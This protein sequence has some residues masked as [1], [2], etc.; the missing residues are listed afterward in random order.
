MIMLDTLNAGYQE[1]SSL[2][3]CSPSE[4]ILIVVILPMSQN[5]FMANEEKYVESVAS[6]A[7]VVKENV[8]VLSVEEISTR[9]STKI[10]L[11]VLLG[12]SVRVQTS[13]LLE[14][15]QQTHLEDVS[16]LNA[17]LVKNGLPN[18]TLAVQFTTQSAGA[19]GVTASSSTT[20]GGETTP[21]P[22]ASKSATTSIG[23]IAGAS[24]GC[25]VLVVYASIVVRNQKLCRSNLL[26]Q[27]P[28]SDLN[29]RRS[30]V[31]KV[32]YLCTVIVFFAMIVV[33]VQA[34]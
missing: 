17:N 12:A 34:R 9:A 21:A 30:L 20:V 8:K 1:N 15:G 24:V 13:V 4:T 14:L 16:L 25:L 29:P 11:R 2:V 7:G 10:A 26:N 5:A 6:T 32:H 19:S 18:G 28:S 3:S 31:Y 27:A 23:T 22:S 33:L